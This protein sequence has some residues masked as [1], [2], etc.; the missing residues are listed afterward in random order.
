MNDIDLQ[1]FLA[2]CGTGLTVGL[3]VGLVKSAVMRSVRS[4]YSYSRQIFH[5]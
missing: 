3:S 4:L 2:L 1:T 5:Q